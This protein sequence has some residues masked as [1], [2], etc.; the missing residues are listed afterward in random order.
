MKKISDGIILAT[1]SPNVFYD[2]AMQFNNAYVF[3]I[4]GGADNEFLDSN[5]FYNL[6]NILSDEELNLIRYNQASVENHPDWL[7]MLK[8]ANNRVL[9][10]KQSTL[11]QELKLKYNLNILNNELET[12]E[13]LENKVNFR[14]LIR[15][16][17]FCPKTQT[18]SKE[19]LLQKTYQEYQFNKFVI[20]G[21]CTSGGNGTYFIFSELDYNLTLDKIKEEEYREYIVTEYIKGE[22]MAA[23]GINY[24]NE[25]VVTS[26]YNQIIGNRNLVLGEISN[27][28]INGKFM[29]NSI[30]NKHILSN[31]TIEYI[32]I[33]GDILNKQF[34]YKG[35]FGIDFII[36]ENQ[37]IKIIECNPRIMGAFPVIDMFYSNVGIPSPLSLHIKEF[38]G[39]NDLDYKYIQKLYINRDSCSMSQII[40][41]IDKNLYTDKILPK[42]SIKPG[43]YN[44]SEDKVVRQSNSLKFENKNQNE[45]IVSAISNNFTKLGKRQRFSR[46]TLSWEFN[47]EENTQ[48]VIKWIKK[49]IILPE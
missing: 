3:S 45:F 48:K 24:G 18:I 39:E 42:Q 26:P 13:Y 40:F 27:L 49:G 22:T 10:Q 41:F 21:D 25:T 29:G 9:F 7:K 19:N 15:Q 5:K 4:R 37:E 44:I 12:Q 30:P 32:Q 11:T 46:I 2:Y 16:Y 47:K 33:I 28:D 1:P 38:I 23:I 43:L 6:D 35:I 34:N 17:S 31:K 20:Q 14:K 36:T 8:K